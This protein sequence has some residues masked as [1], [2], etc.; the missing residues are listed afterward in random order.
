MGSC[1]VSLSGLKYQR[2]SRG[3][4][5][6]TQ[7]SCLLPDMISI[8]PGGNPVATW[9]MATQKG[10]QCGGECMSKI[11][12][13]IWQCLWHCIWQWYVAMGSNVWQCIETYCSARQCSQWV[14]VPLS[15]HNGPLHPDLTG[16]QRSRGKKK[17]RKETNPYH[18]ALKDK[19]A[20]ESGIQ[21]GYWISNCALCPLPRSDGRLGDFGRAVNMPED[22]W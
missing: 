12:Q 20:S 13:S 9:A 22:L 6:A 17:V 8:V 5:W 3:I 4:S 16:P 21:S 2:R 7:S 10:G 18:S 15:F 1:H 11:W 14:Y 19:S